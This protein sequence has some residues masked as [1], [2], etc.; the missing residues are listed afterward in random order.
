MIS[1]KAKEYSTKQVI[2][3]ITPFVLTVVFLFL[4]FRNVEFSKTAE[5]V[6]EASIKW[7]LAFVL[8]FFFSH[9]L[10][11]V[12]WKVMLQSVKKDLSIRNLFGAVMIGYGVNCA[13]PRLGEV[14]RAF[15]LGKWENL[16]RTSM[17][18]TVIVERIIDIISLLLSVLVSIYVYNGNLLIEIEW[19][20]SALFIVGI[21]IAALILFLIALVFFREKVSSVILKGVGKFSGKAAD[22]LNHIFEMLTNGFSTIKSAKSLSVTLF[23]SVFIMVVYGINSYIGLLMLH[24]DTMQPV[25]LS[26]GWVL[27]TIAAFGIVLPTPGGTGSYHIITK[28]TLVG[29]YGFSENISLA[30]AFLTHIIAYVLF[31]AST[32]MV[33]FLSNVRLRREGKEKVNFIS[34][35]K[36]NSDE[37]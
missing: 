19:L 25:N 24:M 31:V 12:R 34:V 1:G 11:A 37:I 17:L 18:G 29:L 9:F 30:Y 33:V 7:M 8:M 4:A 14:Y 2:G 27:M 22:K 32:I 6:S 10:R 35:F 21:A 15:F 36:N 5:L 20:S 13:V 23:L 28:L 26:M 16:S 3:L